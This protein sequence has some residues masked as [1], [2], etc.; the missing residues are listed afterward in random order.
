[1]RIRCP[2]GGKGDAA[3]TSGMKKPPSHQGWG[4]HRRRSAAVAGEVEVGTAAAA[5]DAATE[6]GVEVRHRRKSPA[7][8]ARPRPPHLPCTSCL[9]VPR[10]GMEEGTAVGGVGSERHQHVAS[11]DVGRG[12]RCHRWGPGRG[13]T[14]VGGGR[15]GAPSM[16]EGTVEGREEVRSRSRIPDATREGE[17]RRKYRKEIMIGVIYINV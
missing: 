10:A 17:R 7:P 3:T 11:G 5:D 16:L 15:G 9:I 1:M 12:R 8:H 6:V 13:A 2:Y 14:A 4:N